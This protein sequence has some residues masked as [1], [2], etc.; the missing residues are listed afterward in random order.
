MSSIVVKVPEDYEGQIL[1]N[2]IQCYNNMYYIKL[3]QKLQESTLQNGTVQAL[4]TI[5]SL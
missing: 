1:I 3:N 2:I 5:Y 4:L